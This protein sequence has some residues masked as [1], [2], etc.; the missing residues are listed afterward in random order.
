MPEACS[1]VE[2]RGFD[3]LV[4]AAKFVTPR[5]FERFIDLM[6][7]FS[8]LAMVAVDGVFETVFGCDELLDSP[9]GA[10]IFLRP[11]GVFEVVQGF[12]KFACLDAGDAHDEGEGQHEKD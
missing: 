12:F 4:D 9:F 5:G 7:G 1:H 3:M 11:L 6:N 10:P 8:P 2:N